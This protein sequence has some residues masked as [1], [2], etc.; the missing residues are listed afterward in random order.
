MN[1]DMLIA[2]GA[3]VGLVLLAIAIAVYIGS[4]PS[5]AAPART[6]PAAAATR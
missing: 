2:G 3:A 5:S 6:A 4:A 1:R